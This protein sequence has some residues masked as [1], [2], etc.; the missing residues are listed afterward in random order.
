M[1]GT[2]ITMGTL[3]TS[4]SNSELPVAR[5]TNIMSFLG[6]VF[7]FFFSFESSPRVGIYF[8]SVSSWHPVLLC[9]L[10]SVVLLLGWARLPFVFDRMCPAPTSSSTA[11][12]LHLPTSNEYLYVYIIVRWATGVTIIAFREE[13]IWSRY[14]DP[15]GAITN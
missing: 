3:P 9:G 5:R 1:P 14:S 11:C 4:T 7:E 10:I 8:S 13:T 2:I 12:A 6:S 15:F